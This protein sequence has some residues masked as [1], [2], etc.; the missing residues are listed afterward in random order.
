MNSSEPISK[1]ALL[2]SEIQGVNR[3]ETIAIIRRKEGGMQTI[4]IKTCVFPI[5]SESAREHN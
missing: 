3:K 5:V 1:S 4:M 2:D